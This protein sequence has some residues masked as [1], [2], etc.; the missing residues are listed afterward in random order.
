[1]EDIN[2]LEEKLKYIISLIARYKEELD[3]NYRIIPNLVNKNRDSITD[4]ELLIHY[5]FKNGIC[6][7]DIAESI[8]K[9]EDRVIEEAIY[10]E[11]IHLKDHCMVKSNKNFKYN[12]N[13]KFQRTMDTFIMDIGMNIWTEYLAYSK[14]YEKY[15]YE[16]TPI[17]AEKLERLFFNINDV[18]K[19]VNDYSLDELE[20]YLRYFNRYIRDVTYFIAVFLALVNNNGESL[21]NIK[22]IKFKRLIIGLEKLLK[23]MNH[24][25]YGK[26]MHKRL[27]FIG[28]Y[29]IT[30]FY[31]PN[32]FIVIRESQT[33]LYSFGYSVETN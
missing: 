16:F 6:Y 1:M 14:Q 32:G 23:K 28:Y 20:E 15:G 18:R 26:Y 33:G 10:H 5:Y 8:L 11:C 30:K 13:L 12:P 17:D 31:M 2:N 19:K 7:F 9:I 3:I 27:Y 29:L 25:T 4:S 21:D 22:N 24:G